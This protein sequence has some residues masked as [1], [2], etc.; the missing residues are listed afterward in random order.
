MRNVIPKLWLVVRP[1]YRLIVITFEL[2]WIGIFLLHRVAQHGA[3][4]LPGFVYVNF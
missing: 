2:F 1:N 4:D 3:T